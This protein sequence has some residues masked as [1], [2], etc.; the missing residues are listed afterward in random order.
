MFLLKAED[1]S[2]EINANTLF[3]KASL[4]IC[5]GERIALIG[6]NGV[7]K[8]TFI[9]GLMGVI[10][11]AKGIIQSKLKANEVGWMDQV[12]IDDGQITTREFIEKENE[13]LYELKRKLKKYEN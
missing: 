11:I 3:E 2:I 13:K 7:G 1:V 8:T 6:N 10:P 9:K 5:E 4:E 12:S